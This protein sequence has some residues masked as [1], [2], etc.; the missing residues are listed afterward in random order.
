MKLRVRTAHGETL[1]VEAEKTDSIA[2]FIAKIDLPANA[3][4]GA[5]CLSLNKRDMLDSESTIE[6]NGIRGGD[7]VH[8]VLRNGGNAVGGSSN[9][10][11]PLASP[12]PTPAVAAASA[13]GAPRSNLYG[14]PTTAPTSDPSGPTTEAG[15]GGLVRDSVGRVWQESVV[16]TSHSNAS[17]AAAGG[18]PAQSRTDPEEARRQRLLAI[19]RR[20]GKSAVEE[21][22]AAIGTQKR[23]RPEGDCGDPARRPGSARCKQPPQVNDA[24]R[25]LRQ[26]NNLGP[27]AAPDACVLGLHCCIVACGYELAQDEGTWLAPGA[28]AGWKGK[29]GSYT[30][31]YLADFEGRKAELTLKCVEMGQEIVVHASLGQGYAARANMR[32]PVPDLVLRRH[33]SD[34]AELAQGGEPLFQA[35]RSKLVATLERQGVGVRR[36]AGGGAR[37]GRATSCAAGVADA[38]MQD[39]DVRPVDVIGRAGFPGLVDQAQTFAVFREG[40]RVAKSL[41]EVRAAIAHET[42]FLFLSV[43]VLLCCAGLSPE[44]ESC[45]PPQAAGAAETSV[46]SV[47]N[48]DWELVEV[49]AGQADWEIV[50]EEGAADE[51]KRAAPAAPGDGAGSWSLPEPLKKSITALPESW[52]RPANGGSHS[53]RYAASVEGGRY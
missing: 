34:E 19:E 41:P 15:G 14:L 5:L 12:P 6:A 39:L 17:G 11:R 30:M 27:L 35:V 26:R 43:H 25:A 29:N 48:P 50:D 31:V 7:L 16:A 20:L 3:Q 9:A 44:R 4:Q 40:L 8:L 47:A 28:G 21:S 38:D 49:G 18:H 53:V 2:S 23:E 13:Q 22:E 42:S 36:G 51:R 37:E 1:K 46:S 10:A 45:P 52:L 32:C 24:L 33:S